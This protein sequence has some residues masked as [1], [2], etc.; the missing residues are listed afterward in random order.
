MDV[1]TFVVSL[2][3]HLFMHAI[4]GKWT[5]A[6]TAVA[7]VLVIFS[8]PFLALGAWVTGITMLVLS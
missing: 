1:L 2:I 8:L 3:R 5:V 6:D 4:T 7:T